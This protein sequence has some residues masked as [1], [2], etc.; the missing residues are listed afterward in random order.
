MASKFYAIFHNLLNSALLLNLSLNV[1]INIILIM[2][3]DKEN[4]N[5]VLD[6]ADIRAD[7][8]TRIAAR[9]SAFD[10]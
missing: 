5:A 8:V 9:S 3:C 2:L 7:C 10:G 1:L 4:N 6:S